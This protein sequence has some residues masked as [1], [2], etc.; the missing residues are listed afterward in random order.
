MCTFR[1][2]RGNQWHDSFIRS[3]RFNTTARFRIGGGITASDHM[4][5]R[6]VF[7]IWISVYESTLERFPVMS[8]V[9]RILERCHTGSRATIPAFESLFF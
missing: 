8:H 6:L 9:T 5:L 4:T 2:K 1:L 7:Q 3:I